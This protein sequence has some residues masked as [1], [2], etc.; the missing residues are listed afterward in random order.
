[1][2]VPLRF[3][4][5]SRSITFTREGDRFQGLDA[6]VCGFIP[7]QGAGAYKNQEAIL[8]DGAVTL[9]IEDGPELNV[10]ALGLALVEPR[11]ELWTGVEVVRGEPFDPLSLWLATVDDKFGMIWQDPDR[12]RHLVQTALRWQCPAL[13]TRDSF[14]YLTRR[15]VQHHATAAVH[16]KLGAYGHGPRGVEL[17]RL[18]HDQIHVWDRAWRHRPEPT[19]SFYP[20]GATVPNP[21]VGR[22]FRKRHGQLVMAWP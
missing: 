11:T 13:I 21:S 14:A 2:V 6:T 19:F 4:T 7:M 10:D 3:A 8:A 17:A 20:V 1:M 18:L 9:T 5:I 16:H 12:D 15:D 22:I